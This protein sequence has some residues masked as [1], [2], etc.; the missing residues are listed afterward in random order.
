MT[1]NIYIPSNTSLLLQKALE[2]KIH[3]IIIESAPGGNYRHLNSFIEHVTNV[4]PNTSVVVEPEG[5]SIGIDQIKRLR[6]QFS[7]KNANNETRIAFIND[8]HTMT[9][10]AQNALLKILEEPPTGTI[11]IINTESLSSLLLTVISRCASI[12]MSK[13]DKD[14]MKDYFISKGHQKAAVDSAI[15][16]SDGWPNLAESILLNESTPFMDELTFAKQLLQYNLTQKLREVDVLSKNKHRIPL[17]LFALERVSKAANTSQ[18]KLKGS[19]GQRWLG[20]MEVVAYSEELLSNNV[21]TR[22]VLTNLMM[23]I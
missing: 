11:F 9:Q 16:I 17:L 8:A 18:V 15:T 19:V 13:P 21:N 4:L 20:I 2:N 12:V 5:K 14:T 6:A 3:A 7:L 22:L 10:E 23:K 1:S